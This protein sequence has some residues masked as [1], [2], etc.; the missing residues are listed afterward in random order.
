M[1]AGVSTRLRVVPAPQAAPMTSARST[2]PARPLVVGMCPMGAGVCRSRRAGVNGQVGTRPV[3]ASCLQP[4]WPPHSARGRGRDQHRHAEAFGG[5]VALLIPPGDV[6][7][8]AKHSV[9][10][11]R[12]EGRPDRLRSCEMFASAAS[13]ERRRPGYN[14]LAYRRSVPENCCFHVTAGGPGPSASLRALVSMRPGA[15]SARSASLL[16]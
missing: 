6:A 4:V 2:A 8:V 3:D 7:F 13:R 9:L 14:S 1:L 10:P 12:D 11:K 16:A 5:I 15:H